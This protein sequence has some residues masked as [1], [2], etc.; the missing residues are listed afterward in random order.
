[1]LKMPTNLPLDAAT[2]L[3]CVGIMVY[4]P[5]KHYQM[6]IAG[7]HFGVVGLGGLGHM[8]IKFGKAFGM[9]VTVFSTSPS[10]EKEAL[11][12]LG[13]DWFIVS[14]D[15][16][17]MKV[18]YFLKTQ[19]SLHMNHCQSSSCWPKL[20]QWM[21]DANVTEFMICL[22]EMLVLNA[23]EL[24]ICRYDMLGVNATKL[25]VHVFGYVGI[26]ADCSRNN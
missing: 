3:L 2:P 21:L 23:T 10:K 25:V 17:Q 1:M 15:P 13:A 12:V 8:A 14:K 6:D 26:C 20:C 9:T 7:K 18:I 16:E 4:S 24:G 19:K 11:E 5:M 22:Y